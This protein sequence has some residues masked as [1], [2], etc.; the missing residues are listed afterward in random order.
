MLKFALD[1]LGGMADLREHSL[2]ENMERLSWTGTAS[3]GYLLLGEFTDYYLFLECETG[4]VVYV[5]HDDYSMSRQSEINNIR[6]YKSTLFKNFHDLLRCLFL[7]AVCDGVTGELE[8]AEGE[9]QCI[10]LYSCGRYRYPAFLLLTAGGRVP[11]NRIKARESEY[12][13]DGI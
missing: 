6:E 4:A 12:K 11:Y 13:E 10:P 5:D 8:D 9:T 3:L 2:R 7:G 1:G